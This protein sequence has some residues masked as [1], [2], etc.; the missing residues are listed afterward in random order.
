MLQAGEPDDYVVATGKPHTVEEFVT[1]AFDHV[2]LDWRD[3]VRF[4]EAFARGASDSPLLV[5]DSTKI[6]DRL[7]WEPEVAFDELVGMMVEADLTELKAQAATGG[8]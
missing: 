7:G 6:R 3:H 1:A 2:G 8:R 4:D 5:G